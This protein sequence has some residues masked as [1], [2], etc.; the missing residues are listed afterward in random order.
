MREQLVEALRCED[1][2]EQGIL[3]LDQFMEAI[4]GLKE[5]I[6]EN[7]LNYMIY[8]VLIRSQNFDNMQYKHLVDLLDEMLAA[9]EDR[10]QS[11]SRKNRPESSSPA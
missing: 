4:T 7:V 9:E 11:T 5:D 10:K 1:Y 6:D 3:D 8:Y 2:E